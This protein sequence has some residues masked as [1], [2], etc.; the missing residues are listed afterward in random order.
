MP[1]YSACQNQ[2]CPKRHSCARYLMIWSEYHQSVGA[3]EGPQDGC[4]IPVA[5][6]PFKCHDPS[7]LHDAMNQRRNNA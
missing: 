3:F 6:A 7:A 5:D 1:D 2:T 4:L